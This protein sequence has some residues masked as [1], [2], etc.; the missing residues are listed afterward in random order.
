MGCVS[1]FPP[2]D[3]PGCR[4][5]T[6]DA[7][8][9][10]DFNRP[11]HA[12]VARNGRI[13]D[14]EKRVA[15]RRR[16]DTVGR[17]DG[18][19]RLRIR[20]GEVDDRLAVAHGDA[21]PEADGSI[22]NAVVFHLVLEDVLTLGNPPQFLRHPPF[23]VGDEFGACAPDD[24][25]TILVREFD[26]APFGDIQ[27]TQ[28]GVESR[29]SVLR[30]VRWL[31]RTTF[32]TSRT[33]SPRRISFIGGSRRPSWYISVAFEANDPGAS[34]PISATCAMLATKASRRHVKDRFEHQVLGHVAAAAVRIVVNDHVP[35]FERF[36][37][38][39][40]DRPLDGMADGTDLGGA[41]F[42]LRKHNAVGIEDRAREVARFIEDRGVRRPDHRARHLA[43]GI[44]HVIVDDRQRDAV[45][46][47]GGCV[48]LRDRHRVRLS[49]GLRCGHRKAELHQPVLPHCEQLPGMHQNRRVALLDHGRT[50]RHR[51]R[52][53]RLLSI[54]RRVD[55]SVPLEIH[56]PRAIPRRH[57]AAGP[58]RKW[59]RRCDAHDRHVEM[60]ELDDLSLDLIAERGL[61]LLSNRS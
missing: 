23:G 3:G 20:A 24:V 25:R 60:D 52:G 45:Q 55:E 7:G 56:A 57:F 54:D 12:V 32:Q 6:T 11:V 31:A 40:R 34:P 47:G 29:P 46:R 16:G 22:D 42:S 35:R 58:Y 4:T 39:L 19:A 59:R 13:G 9:R 51:P 48:G 43:A 53:Q 33:C 27:G 50:G 36:T 30:G 49:S 61:V 18:S 38:Q 8:R 37:A 14:L 10:D 15:G 44:D 17:V 2:T 41:S 28:H 21:H 1:V 5:L 26:D